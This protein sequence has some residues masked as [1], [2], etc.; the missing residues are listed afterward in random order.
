MFL[1]FS[2]VCLMQL[3]QLAL[4]IFLSKDPTKPTSVETTE[5]FACRPLEFVSLP[6]RLKYTES[7]TKLY[8]SGLYKSY[9]RIMADD[10][11]TPEQKAKIARHFLYV[12]PHGE[13]NDLVK[14]LK[15]VV[16]S[17]IINDNWLFE[18]M[19]E[20]NKRRFEIVSG[21]TSKVICCPQAE[22][23]PNKYLN[24][25]NQTIYTVDPVKQVNFI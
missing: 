23:E 11:Y 14:D 7:E 19:S 17:N 24:P 5:L 9:Y 18:S 16:P 3:Q 4:H 20:Y 25:D 13:V 1:L 10:E 21:D 2:N 12:T 6:L 15:K 22:V 8:F